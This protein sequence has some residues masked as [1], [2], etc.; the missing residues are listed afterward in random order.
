MATFSVMICAGELVAFRV[1]YPSRDAAGICGVQ[2]GLLQQRALAV[3][4]GHINTYI[5]FRHLLRCVS[6]CRGAYAGAKSS[7]ERHGFGVVLRSCGT[8][9]IRAAMDSSQWRHVL[10]HAR[11]HT[12]PMGTQNSR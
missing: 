8:L 6:I 12:E 4:R 2:L 1:S 7:A 11:Q 5:I 10:C 3:C 9:T